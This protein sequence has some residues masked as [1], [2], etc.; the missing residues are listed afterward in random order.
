MCL[1]SLELNQGIVTIINKNDQRI[2]NIIIR[3]TDNVY[4]EEV[5]NVKN[6]LKESMT[7]WDDVKAGLEKDG[8]AKGQLKSLCTTCD[9]RGELCKI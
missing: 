7:I 3:T 4:V 2:K 1:V 5:G 6:T 8:Y 9:Y